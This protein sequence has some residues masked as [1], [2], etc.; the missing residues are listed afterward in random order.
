VFDSVTSMSEEVHFIYITAVPF[1]GESGQNVFET[2][3]INQLS[4]AGS[5]RPGLVVQVFCAAPIAGPRTLENRSR[6]C[7]LPLYGKTKRQYL[8]FQWRLL[9]GLGRYLWKYRRS[10]S[11]VFMRYHDSMIAPLILHVLFRFTLLMRTGPVLPNLF[12]HGKN[13]NWLTYQV[14]RISLG[15]FYRRASTIV[16][17]TSRIKQWVETTYRIPQEKLV[18]IPNA[19]DPSVFFPETGNRQAWGLPDEAVVIGFVGYVYVDQGLATVLN[20]MA[21]L[22]RR[23]LHL[24]VVGDGP[25]VDSLRRLASDLGIVDN[26]HWAGRVDQP[27]VREAINSCDVM[28]APFTRRAF[29]TT[30]SSALKLF[31]YLACDKP[32][33]ASGDPD[34]QFIR[35]HA[36]GDLVPPEDTSA[37]TAA[38]QRIDEWRGGLRGRGREF[39]VRHRTYEAIATRFI[40]LGLK[41][42]EC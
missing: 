20:S 21:C 26:V 40:E 37:W 2:N 13:P 15:M 28:L 11:I 22:D 6:V 30:G 5:Q 23:D 24:L 34:H 17:V 19:V 32:V 7:L 38:F 18:V 4:R 9:R 35:D 42:A 12:I 31:E 29:Q 14:I 8:A 10:R 27:T 25:E 36:L 16:T 41:C 33:L 3:I 39:V 1:T